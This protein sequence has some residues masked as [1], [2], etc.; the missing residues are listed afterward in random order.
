MSQ[1]A[2]SVVSSERQKGQHR[3]NSP[4]TIGMQKVRQLPPPFLPL[5]LLTLPDRAV[6]SPQKEIRNANSAEGILV[7]QRLIS[8]QPV[9]I[10]GQLVSIFSAKQDKRM[11][12][13][14][15]WVAQ[16]L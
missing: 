15:E 1:D 2:A 14:L 3:L 8:T 9:D 7:G 12:K 16:G 10:G 6:H 5:V 4:S 11:C 13:C